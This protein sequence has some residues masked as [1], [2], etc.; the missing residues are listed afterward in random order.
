MHR[1]INRDTYIKTQVQTEESGK[2]AVRYT[3]LIQLGK[4]KWKQVTILIV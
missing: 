2:K 3:A 1:Y 4:V